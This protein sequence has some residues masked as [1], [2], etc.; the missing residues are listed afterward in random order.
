MQRLITLD[1]S[2]QNYAWGST[3][4]LPELL[5]EEP[6]GQPHAELWVGDHPVNPSLAHLDGG[7]EP[8]SDVIA[9]D[10]ISMLGSSLGGRRSS[11]PYL[12][13]ILAIAQPLSLQAH[14]DMEQARLG[15]ER[16]N[17]A[18]VPVDAKHRN[19]RD[20]SH[21][22]ELI[23]ALEPVEAL[24]GFRDAVDVA[25]DLAKLRGPAT[26]D[27]AES[28]SE[29]PD[30]QGLL[31][32][33]GAILSADDDVA[34][35]M[36]AELRDGIDRLDA[37]Q[38]AL[39]GSLHAAYPDDHTVLIALLLRHL[40]LAPGDALFLG[41]G[42]LHAYLDGVGVEVMAAS[43]NVLRGG[44][45]PKHVDPVE[46]LDI[47]RPEIGGGLLVTPDG[48]AAGIGTYK[49]P[50]DDFVVSRVRA[51]ANV[52]RRRLASTG[53]AVVL[54]TSGEITVD[55]DGET[56][57]L[58]PGHAALATGPSDVVI[59]GDGVGWHVVTDSVAVLGDGEEPVDDLWT[60]E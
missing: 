56:V 19:Y 13:K 1:C 60:E 7:V 26:Q 21:K 24:C 38:G 10:P 43:D 55:A 44:M 34:A 15:F 50:V 58:G 3:T 16:E 28:L 22:P 4:V 18:G 30:G 14:P 36:L 46:L 33:V 48:S 27:L 35:M 31:T 59:T 42:V 29:Q 5:G 25:A 23:V 11:L 40:R 53:P 37:H 20:A 32:I 9:A 12:V 8:L 2:T 39:M 54:C 45:T 41:P 49:V 47:L 52:K 57:T 6:D 17:E 51:E